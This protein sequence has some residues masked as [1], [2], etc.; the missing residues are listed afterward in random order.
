MPRLN[1]SLGIFISRIISLHLLMSMS[2]MAWFQ[3]LGFFQESPM[4]GRVQHSLDR[5]PRCSARY[6]M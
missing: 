3:Q 5:F 2:E 6:C 1:T 4:R